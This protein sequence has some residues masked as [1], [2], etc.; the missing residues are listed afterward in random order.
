MKFK[1]ITIEAIRTTTYVV[2]V[3]EDWDDESTY[4]YA[5]LDEAAIEIDQET[6]NI[7]QKPSGEDE[8]EAFARETE[9]VF[10][11]T[12]KRNVNG[13]DLIGCCKTYRQQKT[14]FDGVEWDDAS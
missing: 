5:I 3:P 4:D 6:N 13:P 10:C 9:P 1:Y 7:E 12:C 2:R 11:P 8:I 14:C